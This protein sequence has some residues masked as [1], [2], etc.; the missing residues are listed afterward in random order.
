V[1]YPVLG[2]LTGHEYMASS[3]FGAPCPAVIYTFG[4]L[5]LA[6]RVPLWLLIVPAI[7]ALIG[8]SA[9]VAFGV[10]QDLGLLAIA[11]LTIPVLTRDQRKHRRRETVLAI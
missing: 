3:P 11:V 6:R 1:I 4:I 2:D 10:W 5:L 7:W 9:V 8:S